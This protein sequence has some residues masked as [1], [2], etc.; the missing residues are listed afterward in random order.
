MKSIIIFM[1]TTLAFTVIAADRYV[2]SNVA[3]DGDGSVNNPWKYLSTAIE[4]SNAG[5]TLF[6]EG[7]FTLE[8]DPAIDKIKGLLIDKSI[9]LIGI[10]PEITIVQATSDPNRDDITWRN[11]T[12]EKG[13]NRTP[14][15]KFENLTIR[16]GY[17]KPAGGIYAEV[18]KNGDEIGELII[19]NCIITDNF[20]PEFLD[21]KTHNGG[22]G[23]FVCGSGNLTI[24]N[25]VIKNNTNF[26][27]DARYGID[28]WVLNAGG[29]I[30]LVPGENSIF[31]LTNTAIYNN[32]AYNSGGGVNIYLPYPSSLTEINFTNCTIS[33]NIAKGLLPS[34]TSGVSYGTAVLIQGTYN[35]ISDPEV[36]FNSCTIA[37]NNGYGLLGKYAIAFICGEYYGYDQSVIT[38][39]NS[40]IKNDHANFYSERLNFFNRSYTISNDNFLPNPRQ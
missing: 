9:S 17:G 25:T 3:T 34:M 39:K 7:I 24:S 37:D 1:L 12:I 29:G 31:N 10:D 32:I 22:A 36:K 14:I 5:D 2:N 38:F 23:I 19:K 33:G 4:S 15:I 8:D 20:T 28:G 35:H 11:F 26:N 16:H 21:M 30:H 6:L 40:I 18:N 27:C 13:N